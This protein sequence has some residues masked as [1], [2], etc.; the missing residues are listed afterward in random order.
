V[1]F[2]ALDKAVADKFKTKII[3]YLRIKEWKLKV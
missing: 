2:V 3:F 1:R